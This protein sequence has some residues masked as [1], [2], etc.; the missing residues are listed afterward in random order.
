[1]G[2]LMESV[3]ACGNIEK[4]QASGGCCFFLWGVDRARPVYEGFC[5]M[6][7]EKPEGVAHWLVA[8]NRSSSQPVGRGWFCAS[9]VG[10]NWVGSFLVGVWMSGLFRFLC[11]SESRGG[12]FLFHRPVAPGL[13]R[14]CSKGNLPFPANRLFLLVGS[15]RLSLRS[16]VPFFDAF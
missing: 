6:G 14:R 7:W 15:S 12:S 8:T 11:I 13:F 5:T 2:R 9:L 16:R 3:S 4:E 10:K 1:M